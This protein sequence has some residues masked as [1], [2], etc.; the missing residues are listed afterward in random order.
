MEW[1]KS[2]VEILRKQRCFLLVVVIE[3]LVSDLLPA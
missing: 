3:L 1:A 2:N